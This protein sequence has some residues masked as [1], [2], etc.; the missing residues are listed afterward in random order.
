VPNK[1]LS[2]EQVLALLSQTP[3][4]IAALTASLEPAQLYVTPNPGE[5]SL[6]EVLAHLRACA[7]VWGNCMVTILTQDRPTLRAV[8]PRTWIESTD[9]LEQEFQLSLQAFTTQRPI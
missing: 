9:Y 6:N 5:W 3:Q 2:R 7:D 4:R 8:N 1:T